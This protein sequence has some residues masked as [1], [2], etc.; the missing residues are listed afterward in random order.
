[1][2]YLQ[3]PTEPQEVRIPRNIIPMLG[4][5]Y[6][7]TLENTIDR[8]RVSVSPSEVVPTALYYTVTVELSDIMPAGEYAY[9][10]R[11]GAAVLAV[12]LMTLGDYQYQ[13]T[14][15]HEAVNYK[16]YEGEE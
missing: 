1:M 13:T 6:V 2:I 8:S 12:G 15:Y 10:L 7:V 4:G 9:E 14:Q 11:K 16:Q 5:E 3:Q